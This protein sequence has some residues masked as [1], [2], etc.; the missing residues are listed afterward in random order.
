MLGRALV[1]GLKLHTEWVDCD[2]TIPN[3]KF[4]GARFCVWR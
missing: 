2:G 1:K 4:V 3:N